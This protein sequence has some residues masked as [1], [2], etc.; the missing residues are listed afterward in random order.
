[1]FFIRQYF[2]RENKMK[3]LT[4][5]IIELDGIQFSD[6]YLRFIP[7]SVRFIFHKSE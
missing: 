4:V 3:Y 7:V 1:M 5:V 2:P 6:N